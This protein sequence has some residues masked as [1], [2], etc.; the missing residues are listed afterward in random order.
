S[1]ESYDKGSAILP[2]C[3]HGCE[4]WR[5]LPPG[6]D[7]RRRHFACKCSCRTKLPNTRLT[8]ASPWPDVTVWGTDF[9]SSSGIL[10][11]VLSCSGLLV[12][13]V[14]ILACTCCKRS[15]VSFKEFENTDAEDEDL[16]VFSPPV[17]DVPSS[18]SGHDVYVLPLNELSHGGQNH[19]YSTDTSR[20]GGVVRQSLSYVQEIGRG[21]FG[22]VLLGE[23]FAGFNPSRVVVKELRANA[24]PEQQ[25]RFLSQVHAYRLL[26]HPNILQCLGQCT[27]RTPYLLV[28]ELCTLVRFGEKLA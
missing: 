23:I 22:K 19:L 7:K 1:L 18:P 15:G 28:M 11:T 24:T 14:L 12:F 17:S 9:L 3:A 21:W 20:S 26:Q 6:L 5:R 13:L 4:W 27:E 25:Q 10:V 2:A 8:T 16:T